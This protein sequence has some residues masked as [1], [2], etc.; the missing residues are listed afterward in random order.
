MT[1]HIGFNPRARAG[2]DNPTK[3]ISMF[4]STRPRG[5]RQT[6]IMLGADKY[7]FQSTRPRGARQPRRER[8]D[9][10][11]V[12]IHA[13]ARGAT[14]ASIQIWRKHV[15]IHAPAR[16]ATYCVP[17]S[18]TTRVSIHAP[19]R[20]A[21]YSTLMRFRRCRFNPRARAGRDM[22]RHLLFMCMFQ[23]TR[24]RGARLPHEASCD[25]EP[26]FNPRARAGR[27]THLCRIAC[28]ITMFQSTRPRGARRAT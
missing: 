5:A 4:Q 11:S 9:S 23:S 17:I 26:S 22:M 13:P 16:G 2:R 21:T 19:A 8:K 28:P 27:D 24:P 15:S 6:L 20:G 1:I 3:H 14:P 10:S 18:V 12:S 25:P 7:V